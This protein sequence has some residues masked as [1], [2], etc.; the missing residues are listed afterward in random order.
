[1]NR[2]ENLK[3]LFASSLG[4]GLLL[5]ACQP[6]EKE[7]DAKGMGTLGG[8]TEEEKLRD[9]QL[10]KEQFFTEE[11]QKKIRTLVDLILPADENSPSATEVGVPEFIEFMMKDQPNLQTPMRGGLQWLDFESDELFGTTFNTLNSSQVK[12]IID[13]VA[14]PDKASAAYSGAVRWFNLLRNLTCSGYFSTEAGWKYMGYMGNQPNVWD[15]VPANVLAKYGLSNPE[16]YAAIYLKPEDRAKVA[17]WD[18]E[19]NLIV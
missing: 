17:T 6:G 7:Q 10:L 12:E 1:M 4:A 16:K 2:R 18:E 8:R 14:W 3:V 19:G 9:A 13:L 11:E 5:N 15:G